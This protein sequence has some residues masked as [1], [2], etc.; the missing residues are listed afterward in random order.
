MSQDINPFETANAGFAQALYEDFLRDPALVSP[1]WRRLFESGFVGEQPPASPSP[2]GS[3]AGTEAADTAPGLAVKG[4]AAR[5]VANM[6]ESLGVPTATTF[7]HLPVS[8]L[9]ARRAQ[10]NQALAASGRDQKISFTHL[11]GFAIVAAARRHPV[12]SHWYKVVDG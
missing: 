10:L 11:I 1:E 9:E 4:P 2:N 7:R 12:M 5:L 8:V 3:G 6:E